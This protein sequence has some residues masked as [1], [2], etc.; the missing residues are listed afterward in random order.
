[1]KSLN[2][3]IKWS[4]LALAI[5]MVGF[6]YI[7]RYYLAGIT[8]FNVKKVELKKAE[9]KKKVDVEMPEEAK[10][11]SISYDGKFVAYIIN[12]EVK[13][14]ERESLKD[15]SVKL[16]QGTKAAN[17]NWLP[18]RN[19]M[20]ISE[21]GNNYVKF[22]S[23]DALKDENIQ[24]I[25]DQSKDVKIVLPSS[26][27]EVKDLAFSVNTSVTYVRIASSSKS[28]IYRFNIMTQLKKQKEY[29]FKMGKIGV[30][31][32]EDR[33]IYEDISNKQLQVEGYGNISRNKLLTNPCFLGADFEDIAYLGSRNGDKITKIYYGLLKNYISTWES[34]DLPTSTL[35]ENISISI[36][37]DIFVNDKLNGKVINLKTS[38]S[39][40]YSGKL[41]AVY[42]D[43]IVSLDGN[44]LKE[45]K[46]N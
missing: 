9:I 23:Y 32:L 37:V 46:L 2:K 14:I 17:L 11:I 29:Y 38:K 33:F 10:S 30:M 20:Y 35:R 8:S 45:N 21:K 18:D 12:G 24:W 16:F 5:E 40:D 4:V 36:D 27:Y 28:L 25:D 26:Q 34:I 7:D 44:T 3:V 15:V 19:I 22:S 42:K 39:S 41:I 13:V 31:Q 6:F 1:M 43:G